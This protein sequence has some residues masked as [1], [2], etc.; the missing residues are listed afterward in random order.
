MEGIEEMRQENGFQEKS[1]SQVSLEEKQ[2]N[3][4]SSS[5]QKE[6]DP[7]VLALIDRQWRGDGATWQTK[8]T[9]K[10]NKSIKNK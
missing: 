9:I 6:K 1:S 5:Q 7:A 2:K 3:T 8:L 4:C 10:M